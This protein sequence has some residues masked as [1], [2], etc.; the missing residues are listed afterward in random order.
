[1]VTLVTEPG[2]GRRVVEPLPGPGN[3]LRIAVGEPGFQSSV[4]RVWANKK[5]DG[6][7]VSHSV[8][9]GIRDLLGFQKYSL[10]RC[11]WFFQ[12]LGDHAK[13]Q[14]SRS[15][16]RV[17]DRWPRP[18]EFAP[19]WTKGVSI[20]I[21]ERD[22]I[23]APELRHSYAADDVLWLPKPKPGHA[24]GIHVVLAKPNH[25]TVEL[26]G[27]VPVA[28]CTL[29]N[30]ECVLVLVG[31]R[32][33]N[34]E[35]Q[36]WLGVMRKSALFQ[37]GRAGIKVPTTASTRLMLHGYDSDGNRMAWDLAVSSLARP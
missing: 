22:V 37:L 21:P 25:G 20:W 30:G 8:Y 16:T 11:E 10:H 18:P 29:L 31:M 32:A 27:A 5:L 34:A 17:L 28:G 26:S 23:E 13:A 1:M 36:A 9:V 24:V 2:D 35:S 33:M 6:D 4:W 12:A 15:G 14:I 3:P 19:G 7:G